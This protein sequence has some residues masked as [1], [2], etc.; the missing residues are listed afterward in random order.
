MCI[1]LLASLADQGRAS[2]KLSDLGTGS[3]VLA[4]AAAKLGW[5]PVIAI[6]NELAALEAAGENAKANGVELQLE[7][8]NLR[9]SWRRR[10]RRHG[11]QP[12]RATAP[13]VRLRARVGRVADPRI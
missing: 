2:G 12:H 6:D 3:G 1:E 13:R 7:R 9:E 11:R 4:I 10:R 8:L 5:D